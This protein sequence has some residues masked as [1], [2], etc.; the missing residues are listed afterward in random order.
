MS[1]N[2]VGELHVSTIVWGIVAAI[3]QQ[4]VEG[5]VEKN[6]HGGLKRQQE[7]QKAGAVRRKPSSKKN[8]K[9][10]R[11]GG[12]TGSRIHEHF[13]LPGPHWA[14]GQSTTRL[15]HARRK[16]N[17]HCCVCDCPPDGSKMQ[18]TYESIV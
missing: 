5:R 8:A 15:P 2:T 1:S 11:E 13:G 9:E 4:E 18:W 3:S 16:K 6:G 14:F 17:E 10:P 12:T 7:G